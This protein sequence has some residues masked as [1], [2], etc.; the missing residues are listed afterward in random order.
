MNLNTIILMA[1]P[2]NGEGGGTQ[3][4]LML[5]LMA[6]VFYF[7]MIRPQMKKQKEQKVFRESLKTGDDAVTIGGVHGKIV[8]LQETTVTLKVE[9]G[10][11]I[12]FERSALI[13]DFKAHQQQQGGKR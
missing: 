11:K 12:K 5:V 9:D 2:A 6:V 7:F 1:Q 10:S 8:S 3:M 4:I 13:A